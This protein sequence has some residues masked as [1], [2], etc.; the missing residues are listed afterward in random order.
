[1]PGRC[2]VVGINN[3]P[4]L[5]PDNLQFTA[6]IIV[7]N[8]GDEPCECRITLYDPEGRLQKQKDLSLN[9]GEEKTA[10]FTA[11]ALLVYGEQVWSGEVIN[12]TRG[13]IDMTYSF[14]IRVLTTTIPY[15]R[16]DITEVTVP[17]THEEAPFGG[18]F[19]NIQSNIYVIIAN[20]GGEAGDCKLVLRDHNNNVITE[21]TE[22]MAPESSISVVLTA[23]TPSPGYY[24]WK[25]ETV[26]LTTNNIDDTYT[27]SFR[28][29]NPNNPNF[30]I[31]SPVSPATVRAQK[32]TRFKVDIKLSNV[33]YAGG[34]AGVRLVNHMGE[35][36]DYKEI[37]L[38]AQTTTS[39]T[40]E[41]TAPDTIGTY[42]WRIQAINKQTNHVDH[43]DSEVLFTLE[44]VEYTPPPPE[45]PTPEQPTQE[46]RKKLP[47]WLLLG[48]VG[49]AIATQIKREEKQ[50][51]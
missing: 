33:G 28:V 37:Y 22:R 34:S 8:V 46:K 29:V 1:M 47:W 49:L 27:F 51:K 21:K 50:P 45:Q 16:F 4:Y 20:N 43:V 9:P 23:T 3:P 5:R 38:Q 13:F 2:V 11:T 30:R 40:L 7:K 36:Q 31:V 17:L 32:N 14:I 44:V 41:A 19:P 42:T 10:S 6:D 48:G 25:V 26:N 12:L 18:K 35:E 24:T 39:L 15:P